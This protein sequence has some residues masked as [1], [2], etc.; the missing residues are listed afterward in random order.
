MASKE[1]YAVLKPGVLTRLALFYA[2]CIMARELK[3]HPEADMTEGQ[4]E[5]GIPATTLEARGS[6]RTLCWL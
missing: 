5:L 6:T 3:M 4:H 1:A 2:R